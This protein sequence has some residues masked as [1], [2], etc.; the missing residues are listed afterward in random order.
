MASVTINNADQ[1]GAQSDWAD[2]NIG[3]AS[4]TITIG[5]LASTSAV[6]DLA[7]IT[8][9]QTWMTTAGDATLTV[10]VAEASTRGA[11]AVVCTGL[12]VGQ[13]GVLGGSTKTLRFEGCDFNPTASSPLQAASGTIAIE[14]VG[15]DHNTAGMSSQ[16]KTQ[17]SGMATG[18][19][20]PERLGLVRHSMLGGTAPV[21][22]SSAQ[23]GGDLALAFS[24]TNAV[25]NNALVDAA[26]TQPTAG[27]V[28]INGNC[29]CV[30]P[31][32]V[33]G[34]AGS[35]VFGGY[36]D[37]NGTTFAHPVIMFSDVAPADGFFEL[38]GGGKAGGIE[39][40]KYPATGGAIVSITGDGEVEAANTLLKSPGGSMGGIKY[41]LHGGATTYAPAVLILER[42]AN[43]K[44][45]LA[46]AVVR[47]SQQLGPV[48]EWANLD[49]SLVS[50][51]QLFSDQQGFL[52]MSRSNF[53]GMSREIPVDTDG[54]PV[55]NGHRLA[56]EI[57]TDVVR[58]EA[59][60]YQVVMAP[61]N[62]FGGS[63]FTTEFSVPAITDAKFPNAS[64]NDVIRNYT[65]KFGPN[66]VTPASSTGRT[67]Q[68][69]AAQ[70]TLVREMGVVFTST[71]KFLG[72]YTFTVRVAATLE[73]SGAV[74]YDIPVTIRHNVYVDG[75]LPAFGVY[76]A[77][78][79]TD[80]TGAASA[81]PLL[82]TVYVNSSD[83][84]VL[85]TTTNL[86]IA[87]TQTRTLRASTKLD[88]VAPFQIKWFD[89][90]SSGQPANR[91]GA[92]DVSSLAPW[93][94]AAAYAWP[95]DYPATDLTGTVNYNVRFTDNKIYQS[96]YTFSRK[97]RATWTRDGS[98]AT[99]AQTP[100][101]FETLSDE[102]TALNPDFAAYADV[103]SPQ[104][105]VF[106]GSATSAQNTVA[107]NTP[108]HDSAYGYALFPS[109]T[110]DTDET[111]LTWSDKV[112]GNTPSTGFFWR[113]AHA[114]AYAYGN[115]T[116]KVE[117][118]YT[119][120]DAA[121]WTVDDIW[122][123]PD[124]GTGTLKSHTDML[125]T[126]GNL[127]TRSVNL[128]N[129][130]NG[131]GTVA[132]DTEN[133]IKTLTFQIPNNQD[134]GKYRGIMIKLAP[135]SSAYSVRTD[136]TAN[137]SF[138]VY[139]SGSTA[140]AGAHDDSKI[141]VADPGSVS[142]K[143]LMFRP[144][145]NLLVLRYAGGAKYAV[146]G[147]GSGVTGNGSAPTASGSTTTIT[148]DTASQPS[149][150]IGAR[151]IGQHGSDNRTL[152]PYVYNTFNATN[153]AIG[154]N[155]TSDAQWI[156]AD[157]ASKT[158]VFNSTNY[159]DFVF[160]PV[161]PTSGRDPQGIS[162]GIA[163]STFKSYDGSHYLNGIPTYSGN[164]NETITAKAYSAS[165]LS[166]VTDLNPGVT[167]QSN[168]A[169]TIRSSTVVP[170]IITT[171]NNTP[172]T[173]T[174]AGTTVYATMEIVHRDANGTRMYPALGA[175]WS[176]SGTTQLKDGNRP[177][178]SSADGATKYNNTGGS[179]SQDISLAGLE[180]MGVAK[181]EVYIGFTG[182][183]SLYPAEDHFPVKADATQMKKIFEL[184]IDMPA[185]TAARTAEANRFYLDANF[186]MVI[187]DGA[188]VV[189]Q[190]INGVW[191]SGPSTDITASDPSWQAGGSSSE[192]ALFGASSAT[193]HGTNEIMAQVTGTTYAID[194]STPADNTTGDTA[195]LL[196]PSY[197]AV[198]E[199][200]V[201]FMTDGTAYIGDVT[202]VVGVGPY[203]VTLA[204]AAGHP[205]G[206]DVDTTRALKQVN[207]VEFAS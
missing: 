77:V 163:L 115:L 136:L 31:L 21:F 62:T 128:A 30:Q 35:E 9:L 158:F 17:R 139:I 55:S 144:Q 93:N 160:T 2:A 54:V 67:V 137:V 188:F 201:A 36:G 180:G 177:E 189:E 170:T 143:T 3:T 40:I 91:L 28:T 125:A 65:A 155:A 58:A 161:A 63:T 53:D 117:A 42:L 202:A 187:V 120:A 121:N 24:A 32:G 13:M 83:A 191:V 99:M 116:V 205:D 204:L 131:G 96:S 82:Q 49:Y 66:N 124:V 195:T 79:A 109:L 89:T 132:T 19:G 6:Y 102:D 76:N 72:D 4:A 69:L 165:A 85:T 123:T 181:I 166:I 164:S 81:R 16:S 52:A 122:V 61:G 200:C 60:S 101:N 33:R 142:A 118:D 75:S 148:V 18:E 68:W 147:D 100:V 183:N 162:V 156:N 48:Y 44:N 119:A 97:A 111:T 151:V 194:N 207:A 104:Y 57:G 153:W 145:S 135:K 203:T 59:W 127:G 179:H 46:D 174:Q 168:V 29:L 169:G 146:S 5:N 7:A 84:D 50:S 114:E 130:S 20:V 90:E 152:V 172:A 98:D 78:Q 43:Y 94:S 157:A 1:T 22:D 126:H 95:E 88:P 206:L 80:S 107:A 25:L 193:T 92:N 133:K 199:Q 110:D 74:H 154:A 173:D 112:T 171:L 8:A 192:D 86:Q 70:Q 134:L 113:A 159:V 103:W 141:V 47:N 87:E 198:G 73:G 11:T 150:T 23:E 39:V 175:V 38:P 184:G 10:K 56:M 178:Y 190:L 71:S 176:T 34:A 149:H 12:S 105:N 15:Y 14:M 197:P 45:S 27:A 37:V 108:N 51:G 186:R 182:T 167:V 196:M 138:K 41:N 185:P 64:D 26:A 106:G 140:P 129:S